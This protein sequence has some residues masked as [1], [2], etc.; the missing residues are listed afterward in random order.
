[1]SE[2]I[3]GIGAKL[4]VGFQSAWGIVPDTPTKQI[5][6]SSEGLKLEKNYIESD[7]LLGLVTTNRMDPAGQECSG[8]VSMIVHPDNIGILLSAAFGSESAA[9]GV[10]DTSTIYAH[11]FSCLP[12]GSAY[13]L[14]ILTLVVDRVKA[15][16]AYPSVKVE[17]M[18][19][20]ATVNDYLRAEF[21][22]R[23]IG[24]ATGTTE[25]LNF[26]SLRPFQF[27]DLAITLGGSATLEATSFKLDLN[28]NLEQGLYTAGE[29]SE[30]SREIEPG[31]RDITLDIEF[32]YGDDSEDLRENY[33]KAGTSIALVATFTSSELAGE[34]EYY[35]LIISLPLAYVID[36]PVNVGNAERI[37]VPIKF[38]ATQSGS[39]QP[40]T[41]ILVDKQATK[42]NA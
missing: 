42:Y 23:G 1:M 19:L 27:R 13:T 7:A 24:E 37:R 18:S 17:S 34:G 5:E 41:V 26:S 11:S 10:G 20:S 31:W 9:A 36:A 40:V 39:T 25:S 15:V 38:K 22:F 28:N 33:F 32:L 3:A 4:Q 16:K 29:S 8:P 30:Y 35:K 6:F 12:A 2:N 14:P 21:N